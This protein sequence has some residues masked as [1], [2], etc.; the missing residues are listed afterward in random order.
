MSEFHEE[1]VGI[2]ESSPHRDFI[3]GSWYEK[4]YIEGSYRTMYVDDIEGP[5]HVQQEYRYHVDLT[6]AIL[7]F[8]ND[9]T[10]LDIGAGVGRQMRAFKE[11]G[12]PNIWG[13][14]ISETAVKASRE[15][16]NILGSLYAMPFEDKQFDIVFSQA[17][18]EHIAPEL[19]MLA[20]KECLRVGKIQVHYMCPEK[21]IDPSHINSIP[22][23][24]WIY[25]WRTL[26]RDL[27]VGVSNPLVPVYPLM[28]VIPQNM[29][30][31]P[32][33]LVLTEKMSVALL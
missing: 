16:N 27:V 30:K 25:K 9:A 13:I 22:I 17:V 31:H 29:V 6:A 12:F 2:I 5:D 19:E 15:E 24:D 4:Q 20:I 10:I 21:G 18:F 28:V 14:D 7:G 1:V 11:R 26:T 3:N 33:A 32:M 23:E 8:D